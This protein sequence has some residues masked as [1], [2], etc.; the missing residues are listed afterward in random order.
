[1]WPE[2]QGAGAV[3]LSGS[4]T[5]GFRIIDRT[6]LDGQQLLY[7]PTALIRPSRSLAD[8][9]RNSIVKLG[10]V[11]VDGH[12][13]L[14]RFQHTS[15]QRAFVNLSTGVISSGESIRAF[16]YAAWSLGVQGPEGFQELLTWQEEGEAVRN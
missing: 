9:R 11:A 5:P 14:L 2:P 15:I 12:E 10:S 16:A 13:L 4:H 1:M 6:A 3:V 8:V 7:F